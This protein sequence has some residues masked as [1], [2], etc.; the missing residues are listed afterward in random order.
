MIDY[1]FSGKVICMGGINM[2]LIMFVDRLPLPGETLVTDSFAEIPGGKGGNQA[3]A[4]ARMLANTHFFG[5]LGKDQYSEC[6][7][8]EM[9]AAGVNMDNVDRDDQVGAGIAMCFVEKSGKNAICFTPGANKRLTPDEIRANAHVFGPG[10]ILLITMEPGRDNVYAAIETAKKRGT[11]V[12][13]D[14][15]PAESD[16]PP[17]IP[18]LVD[19][20]KPNEMEAGIITGIPVT[21]VES[22]GKALR[23][24]LAMGFRTPIVTLGEH[25]SVIWRDG[26]YWHIE[27]I[28]VASIDTIAAG[29]VFNGSLAASLSRGEGLD[30]ALEFACA[31]SALSTTKQGA[32]S[33]VPSYE[34]ALAIMRKM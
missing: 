21:D 4:A 34:E 29:D 23:K 26:G 22:A 12:M 27:P 32:Q 17:H 30:F 15:A 3:Y 8:R 28:P 11:F 1:K 7:L 16:I 6:L 9:L 2:D 13:L 25:G 20:V 18:A 10:D 24:L 5:K 33:S 14:P 31:A 19:I